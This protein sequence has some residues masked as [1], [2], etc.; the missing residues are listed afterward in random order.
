MILED[1]KS[2]AEELYYEKKE[3]ELGYTK[4]IVF[5]SKE[6]TYTL[7]E[8]KIFERLVKPRRIN[9]EVAS[10]HRDIV[11]NHK[12]AI[13]H[14]KMIDSQFNI[15][16]NVS[17]FEEID[18]CLKWQ[19]EELY[20]YHNHINVSIRFKKQSVRFFDCTEKLNLHTHTIDVL[21]SCNDLESYIKS[22]IYAKFKCHGRTELI[23][24]EHRLKHIKKIFNDF[25]IKVNHKFKSLSLKQKGKE[26]Y[27]G[28]LPHKRGNC[29][30]FK[31]LKKQKNAKLK[32][33]R[34]FYKNVLH[35]RYTQKPT[36]EHSIFSKLGIRI[37]QF[38][39]KYFDTN[40][41]KHVLYRT[42]NK[43]FSIIKNGSKKIDLNP[44]AKDKKSFLYYTASLFKK[45]ILRLEVCE[46]FRLILFVKNNRPTT[47]WIEVLNLKT[48]EK[49]TFEESVI[50]NESY[51]QEN[52]LIY[53]DSSSL[54][55]LFKELRVRGIQSKSK[56]INF[57][58]QKEFYIR[59]Y[60]SDVWVKYL[61]YI[62]YETK[63]MNLDRYMSL[64]IDNHNENRSYKIANYELF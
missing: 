5:T 26:F 50:K 3:K 29:I 2:D 9:S 61:E 30:Y 42:S 24:T 60:I 48:Y 47:K 22:I 20:K 18:S 53:F 44:T 64:L 54:N 15:P 46:S 23:V 55:Q 41:Q 38:S 32:M 45:H 13:F 58:Q 62:H 40:V 36:K 59:K 49:E 4:N 21:K 14:T 35:E 57:Y 6:R 34:Y 37:Q 28:G 10:V 12:I 11:D 39:K 1:Y 7:E 43:L 27:I 56:F 25:K 16:Q 33:I 51:V 63:G 31:V 19:Y 52:K 8:V 17:S